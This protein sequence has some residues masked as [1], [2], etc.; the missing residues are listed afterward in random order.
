MVITN[1][2]ITEFH[3]FKIKFIIKTGLVELFISNFA[4]S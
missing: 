3:K 2:L 1:L 4:V